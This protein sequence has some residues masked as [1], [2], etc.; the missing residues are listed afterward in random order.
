MDET[1]E[2][3]GIYLA[4]CREG[5]GLAHAEVETRAV[6]IGT[7]I[8]RKALAA[9]EKGDRV[10]LIS[11]LR[12]LTD[13]YHIDFT[14]ALEA[15]DQWASRRDVK[16]EWSIPD[17]D[18]LLKLAVSLWKIGKLRDAL[19]LFTFLRKRTEHLEL[20]NP[21]RQRFLLAFAT[22]VGSIGQHRIAL[23]IA[24][25][26]LGE[27]PRVS[28][29]AAILCLAGVCW[30][31]LGS[32][33]PAM[34]FLIEAEAK[35]GE[36]VRLKANILHAKANTLVLSGRYRQAGQMIEEA[37][38]LYRSVYDGY[39]DCKCYGTRFS[40]HAGLGEWEAA[41]QNARDGR[42]NAAEQGYDRLVAM[43]LQQEGKALIALEK[44]AEAIPVLLQGLA[45]TVSVGDRDTEFHCHFY[46]WR[47]Y[48]AL[49]AADGR[50]QEPVE[51]ERGALQATM[52]CH[53]F[54]EEMSPEA[55]EIR[56]LMEQTEMFQRWS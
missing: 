27:R 42:A 31:R 30:Y 47:A 2:S 53:Q 56:S 11:E 16:V 10:P 50:R 51:K 28:L 13:I 22:A 1:H 23:E 3:L 34:A 9:M 17:L 55:E 15:Y 41:L 19:A 25:Q 35:A 43:R 5:T 38:S 7:P 36:N 12:V 4:R 8:S 21:D 44:H 48:R 49:R 45:K 39:H 46:L 29:V 14:E 54:V 40:A 20:G 37:R 26:L 52:K 33:E 18:T 32:P 24:E 6:E